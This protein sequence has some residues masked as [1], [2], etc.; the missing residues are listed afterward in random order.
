MTKVKY[1]TLILIA[2]VLILIMPNISN[3]ATEYTYSDT[4]QGIEWGYELDDSNNVVNLKCKTTSIIGSVTIPST[5][6]GKTVISLYGGTY[7][8]SGGA[9]KECSGLTGITIPDTITTIGNYAFQDCT[10][11]KSVTIPNSITSIGEFAFDGCSGLTSVT[12]STNLTKIDNG[13]F[14]DCTG[15]KS[16]TIPDSVTAI[17]EYAFRNCSGLKEINLSK[18]LSKIADRT[19]EGCSGLTSVVIPESVTTIEGSYTNIYGAFG[20]CKNLE[21]V[22]IPD[23][24]ASIGV[25]A[26]RGCDKIT[27]YGNDGMKSKEYAEANEIPFDYISNW[28]KETSAKDITA[29]TLENIEITYKSVMNYDKDTNKNMYMVPA[30]A[31]LVIN[32]EFSEV[33]EGTAPILTIKFGDGEN[34]QVKEGTVGGSIVTYIYTVKNTDKGIMSVVSY[35]GGELKDVAGNI[36]TLSC[37]TLTIQYCS[38]D[39]VYANGT[40]T[41]PDTNGSTSSGTNTETNNNTTTGTSTGTSNTTSKD[42][43]KDTSTGATATKNTENEEDT[44]KAPGTIPYAGVEI[45]TIIAI[46]ALI[47]A[48]VIVYNRYNKFRD[49]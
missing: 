23:T 7:S 48:S 42:A 26:F 25:G 22:L 33:V 5:I 27:I 37:P 15:L 30:D 4:A 40:A 21:K 1:L 19:F 38:G 49:I 9:F 3:A 13:A 35:S 41:N 43:N 36:A 8:W 10:G 34:I 46:I 44:T 24:V 12:L 31:K 17:G 20:D 29:P 6:D 11:L 16:I 32:V 14:L 47:V 45:G 39:F 2:L 18:N 28:D